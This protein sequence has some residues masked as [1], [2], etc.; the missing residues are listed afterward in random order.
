MCRK[1]EIS[2]T[3]TNLP[4]IM[5]YLISFYRCFTHRSHTLCSSTKL[6]TRKNKNASHYT[7]CCRMSMLYRETIKQMVKKQI[8]FQ[9]I[10]LDLVFGTWHKQKISL[11]DANLVRTMANCEEK[12]YEKTTTSSRKLFSHNRKTKHPN[13]CGWF[14]SLKINWFSLLRFPSYY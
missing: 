6:K 8:Y 13:V 10:H 3:W 14:D 2:N 9:N 5:C 11:S 4:K 7:F 1:V 12:I